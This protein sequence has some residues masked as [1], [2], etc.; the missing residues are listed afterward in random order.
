MT[1]EAAGYVLAGGLSSRMGRD[2]ALLA[3]QGQTLLERS[4]HILQRAG[5]PASIAGGAPELARFAPLI[6]D[7]QPDLGPLSGICTAL[8]ACP[9]PLAVFLPVDLPLLPPA[10]IRALWERARSTAA[11]VTLASCNGFVESFPVV[12]HR[13]ALGSLAGALAS[14]QRGCLQSFRAAAESLG[15]PLAVLEAESLD[16][17]NAARLPAAEWFLNVNCAEDFQRAVQHLATLIP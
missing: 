8:A 13:D 1:L 17:E 12:L 6:A 10:L 15:R 16:G 4:L 9:A 3:L 5:L 2:K 14:A 7:A 11:P